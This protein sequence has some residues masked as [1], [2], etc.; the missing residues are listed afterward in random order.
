MTWT[1]LR[2]LLALK[3]TGGIPWLYVVPILAALIEFAIPWLGSAPRLPYTI[4]LMFLVAVFLFL[5]GLV[6]TIGCPPTLKEIGSQ[7]EWSKATAIKRS[8]FLVRVEQDKILMS[9]LLI[10]AEKLIDQRLTPAFATDQIEIIK[11]ELLQGVQGKTSFLGETIINVAGTS[12]STFN[13]LNTQNPVARWTCT[14]LIVL[15]FIPFLAAIVLRFI[16]V[17]HGTFG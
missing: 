14:S 13:K 3:L 5:A 11:R 6:Y 8:E 10:E 15:A 4:V 16:S 7:D 9:A 2:R 1:S 12:I 17:Y